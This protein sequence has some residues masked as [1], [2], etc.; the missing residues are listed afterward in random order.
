M[1]DLRG[2]RLWAMLRQSRN[3]V[4]SVPDWSSAVLER[5]HHKDQT[6]AEAAFVLPT[7]GAPGGPQTG[8]THEA[9][10]RSGG[11]GSATGAPAARAS[12]SFRY[13]AAGDYWFDRDAAVARP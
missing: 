7:G 8:T 4:S 6:D 11:A 9:G 2:A 10:Y 3:P 13:L 5:K 1:I 12:R